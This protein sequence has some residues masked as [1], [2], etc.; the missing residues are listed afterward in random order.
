M[1]DPLGRE[2]SLLP[3]TILHLCSVR[4]QEG[5]A[6]MAVRLA[7]LTRERGP[8]VLVGAPADSSVRREAAEIQGLDLVD[9]LHPDRGISTLGFWRDV[10][11]LRRVLV[12]ERVGI[13]HAWRPEDLCAGLLAR[14]GL[15][16]RVVFTCDRTEPVGSAP[17][18][19]VQ[20][21]RIDRLHVTCRR[22]ET[23]YREAA[24]EPARIRLVHDGV[25][26]QRFH[27]RVPGQGLRSE[28]GL[29][30]G[31]VVLGCVGRLEPVKGHARLL[32]ILAGLC[33]EFEKLHL[34]LAGDGSE[35]EALQRQA[36]DAGIAD[37]VHL[38]GRREDIPRVL[39]AC[40]AYV[41][42]TL[43]GEGSS[44]ATIEAMAAGLPVVAS[45]IGMLPD[46]IQPGLNGYLVPP[47]EAA[48]WTA[49][50]R[51]VVRDRGLRE[52]MGLNA[53]VAAEEHFDENRM[54]DE[55][56]TL[57]REVAEGAAPAQPPAEDSAE[58]V[59]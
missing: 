34:L 31:A 54:T 19:R 35:R 42:P 10:L 14:T 7:A 29:P 48:E 20:Q 45:D 58:D 1:T 44:R 17:H 38:L 37:R 5:T 59:G 47:H 40:D 4:S 3:R 27:P 24:V 11:R 39:A 55:I 36:R 18:H 56:L 6:T 28:A 57:Y 50:L 15:S 13:L 9:G 23:I 8:R 43:D 41:L 32:A 46:A 33:G 12:R 52:A 49:R 30:G 2:P 25:D 16:I 53:R 26:L 22:I 51:A 21:R